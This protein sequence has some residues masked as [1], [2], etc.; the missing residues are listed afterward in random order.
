MRYHFFPNQMKC[1]K[2]TDATRAAAAGVRREKHY[3]VKFLVADVA[4]KLQILSIEIRELYQ[5]AKGQLYIVDAIG[6]SFQR[7]DGKRHVEARAAKLIS[8]VKCL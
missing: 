4:V 2:Q 8:P 7:I 6:V 3:R 1:P 5:F